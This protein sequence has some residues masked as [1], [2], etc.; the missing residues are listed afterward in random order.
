MSEIQMP[1]RGDPP[2]PPPAPRPP[3]GRDPRDGSLALGVG[4]AW[5]INVVGSI[6]IFGIAMLLAGRSRSPSAP[7]FVLGWL[8]FLASVG[9]AVWMIVKGPRRTGI[10]IIIG[11]GSMWAVSLLLVAACFGIFFLGNWH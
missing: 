2:V 7:L 10:G 6:V 8:P 1:E 3:P 5:G 11:I 4:L 9:L